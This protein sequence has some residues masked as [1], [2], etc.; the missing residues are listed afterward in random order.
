MSF[1]LN[2][3]VVEQIAD[4]CF[5]PSA[6]SLRDNAN[7]RAIAATRRFTGQYISGASVSPRM[8]LPCRGLGNMGLRIICVRPLDPSA[9]SHWEPYL[10]QLCLERIFPAAAVACTLRDDWTVPAPDH[11]PLF[12]RAIFLAK[13]K[14]FFRRQ[15][16]AGL[17]RL[18]QNLSALP[19][20][21][22]SL[23]RGSML[24]LHALIHS[25]S[26]DDVQVEACASHILMRHLSPLQH[27]SQSSHTNELIAYA[28][29]DDRTAALLERVLGWCRKYALGHQDY[30][31]KE[32][33]TT[34]T[35]RALQSDHLTDILPSGW[36]YDGGTFIEIHGTRREIRPDME[37]LIDQYLIEKNASIKQY[38]LALDEVLRVI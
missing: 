35:L 12:E 16:A 25:S 8:S 24:S 32:D 5:Q 15:R 20:G 30:A 9:A 1:S 26:A 19:V 31:T 27:S 2:S 13:V 7:T 3:D 38:N 17:K 29:C 6:S 22:L 34:Q 11:R 4:T 10:L 36:W 18:E 23:L 21:E 28:V 14:I 33:V 37:G